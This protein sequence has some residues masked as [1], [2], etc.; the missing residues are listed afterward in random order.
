MRGQG[1]TTRIPLR[2]STVETGKRARLH[3]LLFGAGLGNGTALLLPY[4]QGLE[5]GPRDFFA[6]PA[7][8]DPRYV[9]E[10]A[11]EGGFNAIAMQYGLAERYYPAYAG[12]IPLIVK[13]NGKT[14]VPPDDEALS[15]LNATVEEAARLGAE[16]VGY[17]LY[18]GSPAQHADLTQF[19]QVRQDAARLGLPLIVWSYPRGSAMK[20]KGGI[21]SFYAVDYAA[22]T[23]SE[24]GADVVKLNFPNPGETENVKSEYTGEFTPQQA[25]HHVVRS[26][27]RSLVLVSGGSMTSD[28]AM[29]EKARMS[30]EAGVTGVIFGRNVWQRDREDSL[31]FVGR[32]RD[33]LKRYPSEP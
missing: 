2:D 29:L 28:E 25:M 31:R 4:D 24:L 5:H 11:I 8:A 27:N 18:V 33:L 32:L 13:L 12:E 7:A 1:V 16:A 6:N 3:R 30:L 10:L 9:F 22:R 23:A 17:T 21:D 19:R 26:A 15:P 20:A 14:D